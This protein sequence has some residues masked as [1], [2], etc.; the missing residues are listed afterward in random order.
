MSLFT[1]QMSLLSPSHAC[2]INSQK[3]LRKDLLQCICFYL[4]PL[5][6]MSN[7]L[8][9]PLARQTK[10]VCIKFLEVYLELWTRN[11]Y[12]LWMT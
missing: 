5:A 3:V 2:K 11:D 8:S 1:S 7:C 12:I 6:G 4:S 10:N 9:T